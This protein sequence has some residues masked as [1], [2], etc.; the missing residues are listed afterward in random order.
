MEHPPRDALFGGDINRNYHYF[1]RSDNGDGGKL[2]FCPILSITWCGLV[3]AFF[4]YQPRKP[5]FKFRLG[6]KK[7]QYFVRLENFFTIF[8]S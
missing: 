6:S 1:Q 3:C 7:G 8:S 5:F 2:L 4:A